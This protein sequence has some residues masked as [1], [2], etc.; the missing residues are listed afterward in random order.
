MDDPAWTR[1]GN[2]AY[3]LQFITEPKGAKPKDALNVLKSLGDESR[4]KAREKYLQETPPEARLTQMDVLNNILKKRQQKDE[5]VSMEREK[6]MDV[7][8]NIIKERQQKTEAAAMEMKKT[9]DLKATA[10]AALDTL[11]S[12]D[13]PTDGCCPYI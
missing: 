9:L 10:R 5:A 11:E 6:Q 3:E 7:L 4:Y 1:N 13:C 8:N 12:R 2:K